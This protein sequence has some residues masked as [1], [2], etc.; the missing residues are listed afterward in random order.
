MTPGVKHLV[1]LDLHKS[2]L[3]NTH[4]MEYMQANNIEVCSFLP[5]C[6]HVLQPL[7]DLS[8]AMLKRKYQK[9]LLPFNLQVAG[10]KLS[11]QQFFQVLVPTFASAF[12][13]EVIRRGFLDTG[14]C[15]L[16]QE[17]PKLQQLGP[18][19]VY[20]KCKSNDVHSDL[21]DIGYC[22][23]IKTK[24]M[25]FRYTWVYSKEDTMAHTYRAMVTS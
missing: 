24:G 9:E 4:Y 18:S 16:N 10:E 5:H 17:V 2:H 19:E 20:N 7:D 6:I 3:F 21:S 15:P 8:Y 13:P 22:H 25:V 14:I 23:A 12:Q 11:K 1:L